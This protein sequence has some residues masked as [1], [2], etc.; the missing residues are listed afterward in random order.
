VRKLVDRAYKGALPD[1]R[2]TLVRM[3]GEFSKLKTKTDWARL[4]V[5]PLLRHVKELEKRLKSPDFSGETARLR[6]GVKQFH[7]DLVYLRD[8]VKWLQEILRSEKGSLT[9]RVRRKRN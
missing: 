2:K 1:F 4:R 6:K 8:N 9:R 7:S 3:R 5:D